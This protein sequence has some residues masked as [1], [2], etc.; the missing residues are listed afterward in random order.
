MER[1]VAGRRDPPDGPLKAY[2]QPLPFT[3]LEEYMEELTEPG[4]V[5]LTPFVQS[6]TAARAAA[7]HGRR[8]ISVH[9]NPLCTLLTRLQLSPPPA[10]LLNRLYA[11]VAA[12]PHMG[13]TLRQHLLDL[14]RGRC[15][16]CGWNL[17]AELFIW[18]REPRKLLARRYR[19][20]SCGSAGEA[21]ADDAD[22]QIAA[23]YPARALSYWRA[24]H[25]LT[26][27]DD[28]AYERLQEL[29][30]LY[31]PRNLYALFELTRRLEAFAGRHPQPEAQD[32]WR[33]LL[34]YCLDAGAGLD[35]P[36]R[37]R[38]TT[39]PAMPARFLERNVW[40]VF[41]EACEWARRLIETRRPLPIATQWQTPLPPTTVT[42]ASV[43]Q[44]RKVLPANGISLIITAPPS[45]EPAF[46]IMSFLWTAWMSGRPQAEPLEP[47]LAHH[48]TDWDWYAEVFQRTLRALTHLLTS[49]GHIVLILRSE[50]ERWIEALMTAVG[51]AGLDIAG[52]ACQPAEPLDGG[53][54][55]AEYRIVLRPGL[56]Q[57]RLTLSLP[58]TQEGLAGGLRLIGRQAVEEVLSL[59]AEPTQGL[60]LH[61]AAYRRLAEAFPWG[62]AGRVPLP[63]PLFYFITDHIW[64]DLAGAGELFPMESDG[65]IPS[66]RPP[67]PGLRPL[68]WWQAGLETSLRQL[69]LT[70]RVERFVRD[71]L[72]REGPAPAPALCRAVYDQFPGFATPPQE[73]IA[74]CLTSYGRPGADNRWE[75][76][77]EDAP[78]RRQ[79][80]CLEL[81]DAIRDIGARMG[82][83]VMRP[84]SPAGQE[85][86][87]LPQ[88]ALWA[89][90]RVW[91]FRVAA[92][93]ALEH[94]RPPAPLLANS[95]LLFLIIPGGRAPLVLYR[96]RACPLW[97]RALQR[98]GWR[99]VKFRLMRRLAGEMPREADELLKMLALDPIIV[100]DEPQAR[101]L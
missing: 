14:Y 59:R 65:E 33:A 25:R 79:A 27:R 93:T 12:S 55:A 52:F 61:A 57:M 90:E 51:M 64:E 41:E 42:T 4:E 53:P 24:L 9:G 66:A 97:N 49:E 35:S 1:F 62:T 73:A 17:S 34:L 70:D 18:E 15:P 47:W 16:H 78:A 63:A 36:E 22:Q 46:W 13:L 74:A 94:L 95:P 82:M 26:R 92:D 67:E 23:A 10:E 58:E 88:D 75:L 28:P 83:Q 86:G 45:P 91:L 98:Y 101:L 11:A 69:P 8:S 44:L 7:A 43:G 31:T 87:L 89:G 72:E 39:R 81:A 84:D 19:C 71:W 3:A 37:V 38:R 2:L 76:R 20:E 30:E 40:L 32:L 77:P 99:L 6:D 100:Q 5:V 68:F 60:Y 56:R 50:Q 85:L 80:E 21:P 96:R 54:P 48:L 29:L